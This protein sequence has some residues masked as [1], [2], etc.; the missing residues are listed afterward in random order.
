LKLT[1]PQ[2]IVVLRDKLQNSMGRHL[3]GILGSYTQLDYFEYH[4][5]SQVK[6]DGQPFPAP[7]NLNRELLARVPDADL[8]Q[9]V[10]DE[11]K[12]RSV[13]RDRL[14]SEL[15]ELLKDLFRQHH[16]VI[17]KQIEL[18]YAY[19]LD[20]SVFRL[21][22]ADRNHLLLLLPGERRGTTITLF[23][24]ASPSSQ[25]TLPDTLITGENLWEL[26]NDQ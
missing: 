1:A 10:R 8:R 22:A 21:A 23:H 15:E 3:Y 18:I 24:E 14:K 19:E 13:I 9:L 17:L 26:S 25:R 2:I 7:T 4:Y 20:L 6:V 5:L 12:R 16:F 11:A